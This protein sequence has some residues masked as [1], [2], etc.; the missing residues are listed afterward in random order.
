MGWRRSCR[1]SLPWRLGL[2]LSAHAIN[3]KALDDDTPLD[4]IPVPTL[5]PACGAT[6]IAATCGC[7]R[8]STTASTSRARPSRSVP[9]YGLLDAGVGLFLWRQ[10]E[11]DFLGRNLLDKAYLVSPDARATLAPGLTLIATA[12]IKF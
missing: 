10:L 9:G 6:W 11:L 12:S 3:G 8:G 7:G 2:E 5:T 4:T 1:P